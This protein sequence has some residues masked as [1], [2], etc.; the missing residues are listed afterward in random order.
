[1]TTTLLP[2][3]QIGVKK[4]T[5]SASVLRE[6]K[7]EKGIGIE[8]GSKKESYVTKL[9]TIRDFFLKK[10]ESDVFSFRQRLK[11]RQDEKRRIREERIEE[12]KKTKKESKSSLVPKF[13]TPGLFKDIFSSIGNFLLFLS[14]G[15]IF[16]NFLDL[17]KSFAVIVK[18]LDVIGGTIKLFASA[19]SGI[20]DFIDSAYKGYDKM[21][22]QISDITGLSEEQINDFLGKFNK[23]INGTIIAAMTVLRTLP[24]ILKNKKPPQPPTSTTTNI[25]RSGQFG[26]GATTGIDL[27]KGTRTIGGKVVSAKSASRYTASVTRFISGKANAGDM[28][29]LVRRGFFKPFAKFT[30]NSKALKVLP[31]GIGSFI[32]FLI[33][34][35]V[36][37]EPAGRAA[38]KSIGAGLFGFLGTLLGGPF[39]LFTGTAGAIAGD[40]AGGK[41]YDGIFGDGLSKDLSGLDEQAFYDQITETRITA[42]QPIVI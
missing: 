10:Y 11:M 27:V 6:L 23:V 33:Q 8:K 12:K 28:M 5:I 31:F 1:M 32:D 18:S 37:K 7:P 22:K 34:Y 21:T 19:V 41:L 24:R 20:T 39:A 4:K 36:F 35:F 29:R 16:N 42:I 14:G 3:A 17:E 40:W 38:F 2:K 15:I 26:G 30:L 13:K 9:E 25:P